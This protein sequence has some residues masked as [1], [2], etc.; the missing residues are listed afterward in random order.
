[1]RTY[2]V[3][4]LMKGTVVETR[5]VNARSPLNAVLVAGWNTKLAIG[6]FDHIEPEAL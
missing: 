3:Q 5:Y 2:S 6:E 1:M 4:F